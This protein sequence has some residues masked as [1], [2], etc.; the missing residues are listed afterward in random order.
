M[1]E[2]L[3]KPFNVK[4]AS[5]EEYRVVNVFSNLMRAEQLPNDPPMPLEEQVQ[6]YRNLPSFLDVYAWGAW[7][8]DESALIADGVVTFLRMEEN[9]H[10]AEM[11]I[12]VLPA[13]RRQGIARRLLALIADTAQRENRQLLISGTNERIPAGEKFMQRLGAQRGLENHTNQLDLADLNR[14]LV[15]DWIALAQTSASDFELGLWDG[16]YPQS[17]IAGIISLFNVMNSAPRGSL[18]VDDFHYTEEHVRQEEKRLFARGTQRWTLY[19]REKSTGKFAGYTEVFWNPNRAQIL[20][21]GAT[22]VFPEYRNKGLG[23]WLKAAMLD[24][25]LRERTQVKYIRTGNADSNAPML[26]INHELGFKPYISRCVW[27]I[28]VSQVFDYLA[29]PVTP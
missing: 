15:N 29:Q 28:Q 24:K 10:V 12:E 20:N 3:I 22:G 4:N 16:A 25:V 17:D 11:N 2:Y 8:A 21:Q 7:N 13:F 1:S 5:D 26:K 19:V 14:A 9:K 27:Q 6:E 23:R 18:Q